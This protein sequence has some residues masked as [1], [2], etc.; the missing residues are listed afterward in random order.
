MALFPKAQNP[1]QQII[2]NQPTYT[3]I[4]PYF[5]EYLVPPN[6]PCTQFFKDIKN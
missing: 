5:L 2:T 4:L 3:F 1:S 6:K